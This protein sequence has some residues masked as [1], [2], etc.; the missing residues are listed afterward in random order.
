MLADTRF[1]RMASVDTVN[2]VDHI[3]DHFA[4][5]IPRIHSP[6]PHTAVV[7]VDRS[8]LPP[9]DQRPV[10]Y[11]RPTQVMSDL[12]LSEPHPGYSGE[13]LD[14]EAKDFA[15]N[16]DGL[17]SLSLTCKKLRAVYRQALSERLL[18]VLPAGCLQFGVGESIYAGR[19]YFKE[20]ASESSHC[21]FPSDWFSPVAPIHRLFPEINMLGVGDHILACASVYSSWAV[22][23]EKRSDIFESITKRKHRIFPAR[24]DG[25]LE[26]FRTRKSRPFA[27]TPALVKKQFSI[28]PLDFIVP[29][30]QVFTSGLVL[31]S[32]KQDEPSTLIKDK[33]F[34]RYKHTD[35]VYPYE[36]PI[37]LN[38]NKPTI[39]TDDC[40]AKLLWPDLPSALGSYEMSE[41]SLSFTWAKLREMRHAVLKTQLPSDPPSIG[42]KRHLF[43][44]PPQN[45][46]KVVALNQHYNQI[47]R[48]AVEDRLQVYSRLQQG[49]QWTGFNA[50]V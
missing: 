39:T 50:F 27:S 25:V 45:M 5:V 28:F 37:V 48:R 22:K 36:W 43:L 4:T 1:F 18:A 34:I 24:E 26:S 13:L 31:E 23:W 46:K 21:N 10:L 11:T 19:Q 6:L 32:F 38:P 8:V 47:H 17:V 35:K 9:D 30:D 49:D 29:P 3:V 15:D 42:R 2:A 41:D 12:H 33:T 44:C 16:E 14:T 20:L 40:V 7:P